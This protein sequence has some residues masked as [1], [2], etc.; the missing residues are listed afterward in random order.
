M[1]DKQIKR[2]QEENNEERT[3]YIPQAIKSF[4]LQLREFVFVCVCVDRIFFGYF[5]M[6]EIRFA[7][8][9]HMTIKWAFVCPSK[10]WVRLIVV[11]AADFF[12]C[13]LFERFKV[14][15]E[16]FVDVWNAH[17]CFVFFRLEIEIDAIDL[18]S[19]PWHFNVNFRLMW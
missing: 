9:I 8:L 14:I 12:S 16:L 7:W 18:K 15:P 2:E 17:I 10:C 19:W 11:A 13:L 4:A 6:A 1:A 3:N 5:Q